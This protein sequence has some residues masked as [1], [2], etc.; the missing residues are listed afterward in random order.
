MSGIFKIRA[1]THPLPKNEIW[2]KTHGMIL[3]LV[4]AC[5]GDC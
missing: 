5:G 2:V 1:I 3:L 4:V